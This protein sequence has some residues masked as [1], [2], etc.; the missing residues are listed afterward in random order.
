MYGD[1]E[2]D[3]E[4]LLSWKSKPRMVRFVSGAVTFLSFL[5]LT[6][7]VL[8]LGGDGGA[9]TISWWSFPVMVTGLLGLFTGM[10]LFINGLYYKPRKEPLLV[11]YD[12]QSLQTCMFMYNGEKV[13]MIKKDT[14]HE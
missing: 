12:P 7:L 11:S 10:V 5:W 8:S 4:I 9:S 14:Q 1:L 3:G 6:P 13:H 2:E